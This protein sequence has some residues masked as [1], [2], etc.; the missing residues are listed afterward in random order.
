MKFTCANGAVA[1]QIADVVVT[2]S[3]GNYNDFDVTLTFVVTSK[4]TVAITGLSAADGIYSGNPHSG[5]NGTISVEGDKVHAN[6]LV[7]SYSGIGDTAYAES[8]T[9]PTDAGSYKLTI[10]VAASNNDYTGRHA[11][12][13]FNITKAPITVKQGG[14][15]IDK[16]WDGTTAATGSGALLL[17]VTSGAPIGAA[18]VTP[19]PRVYPNSDVSTNH[20]VIVDL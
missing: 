17:T 15:T 3:S 7:Y 12:V 19:T 1:G 13:T 14:Y 20:S 4:T 16:I 2:V 8:S 18:T 6:E 11:V 5:F 9:P 10:S